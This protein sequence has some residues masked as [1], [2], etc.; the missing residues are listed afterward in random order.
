[1]ELSPVDSKKITVSGSTTRVALVATCL[2]SKGTQNLSVELRRS[3]IGSWRMAGVGYW[4]SNCEPTERTNQPQPSDRLG[5]PDE[6]SSERLEPIKVSIK[7]GQG[8]LDSG[9]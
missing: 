2:V 5:S 7:P 1:M 4:V 9:V 6:L 8:I 3:I